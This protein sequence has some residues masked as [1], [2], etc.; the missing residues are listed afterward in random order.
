MKSLSIIIVTYNSQKDIL[1]C[2]SSIFETSDIPRE[3]IDIIVIDN[4]SKEVF[5]ETEELIISQYGTEINIIRNSKNGGYGQGNNFG[6]QYA[7]A[8][9]ICI[10]NPD[11]I[12]LKPIFQE[13][14]NMFIVNERL[15]MI[16]GKQF[17]GGDISYWI[18]PEYDFFL[19][20]AP[21]SK[22]LNKFNIYLQKYFYL[23]GALLFVSKTK[24][25]EI[26]GFDEKMFMYCEEADITKRFLQKNYE[27]SYRKDFHYQHLIDE[28]SE[29]GEMSL[30]FLINSYKI[31]FSK[32]DFNYRGFMRRR[33]FTFKALMLFGKLFG[34][35]QLH[36]KN[37]KYFEIF[38][39]LQ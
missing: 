26:G 13:A 2:L 23:S 15:A 25:L 28:R 37:L 10:V 38:R 21:I 4:S 12:F 35:K 29:A 34:N 6:I 1:N 5:I 22:I 39:K 8:E 27:T 32:F 24:F 36:N 17:G 14:L 3:A 30:K 19:F 11:V 18:R 9:V 33:I 20:T 7:M 31:Y 16:G